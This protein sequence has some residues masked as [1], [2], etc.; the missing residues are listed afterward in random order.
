MYLVELERKRR[1]S[2]YKMEEWEK[3]ATWLLSDR[4]H[5]LTHKHKRRHIRQSSK[6]HSKQ[7][8]YDL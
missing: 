6:S 3:N 4:A 1:K 7:A 2:E 8:A 5:V